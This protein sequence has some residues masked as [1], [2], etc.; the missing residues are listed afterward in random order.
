MKQKTGRKL[1]GVLLTLAM[2]VGLMP[3]MS[4]TAYA[5]NTEELLTTITA[6]GTEQASYSTPNV[7]TVSFSN[8]PNCNSS[9]LANWGWWGYGWSATVNAAEGYTITKC[10]FYDDANRTATDSS[11]PFVVE[12]TEE[13][14]TPRI[15][16]SP[17]DGGNN[18]SKG[19][20]K[21]E[22]YG[23]A[24]PETPSGYTI[25]IPSTLAVANSGWNATDGISATGTLASGKK[26]TVTASSANSWALKSGDN[27]VG[28]T[29]TTA[30]GGSQTTSWEFTTLDGTA[31]PMGI[32][33]ENYDNKPAGTYTD[34][35]TFTAAVENAGIPVSS[36][37][38][39]NAPTEALFVNSTGT[40][41]ATVLP[42]DATDKTVTW[43][44]DNPNHV[45]IDAATGEYTVTG[46]D[47]YGSAT[48]TAT[49]TN[50]TEDTSD[51]VTATCTIAGKVT[52]TSLSA[53]TVL[54]V[55]DT[56]YAGKVF[57]DT[58]PGMSFNDS[59][60]VITL[61][62]DNGC[63]KFKRGSNGTMPN[64]TAYKIKDNTDG[65]YIVSGGGTSTSDKFTLA[66]HTK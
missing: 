57:F 61:V 55:G 10:V 3:S 49:A 26:L 30:E 9:Y 41:T 20:K 48:I 60:G 12:T 38:I 4:L 15:N 43:S 32:I 27:S 64:V 18:Q 14:K 33:V 36:V 42:N 5:D 37:T 65:V 21:I 58:K 54:H 25:T 52:Y 11:S 28:Y 47:G 40:L 22:V 63:Y 7:A 56:F 31:K 66:V 34:T 13:D 16:G 45:K 2:V 24:A 53:G 62:E 6:T 1:L 35:V 50:G 59:N 51:D 17:I 46:V 29:L 39:N 19:L 44:S 8:L 23:Y